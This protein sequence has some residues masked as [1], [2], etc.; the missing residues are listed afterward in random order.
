M[1]LVFTSCPQPQTHM[2]QKAKINYYPCHWMAS[3]T[4]SL[5]FNFLS[6]YFMQSFS[7]RSKSN[8]VHILKPEWLN[9]DTRFMFPRYGRSMTNISFSI[10]RNRMMELV[11]E[12]PR[13]T[14]FLRSKCHYDY[15]TLWY[16]YNSFQT[17]I[18]LCSSEMQRLWLPQQYTWNQN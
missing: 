8:N 18:K 2:E 14:H 6:H 9:F 7:F 10:N 17:K 12:N 16:I 13:Y 11:S 15:A 1:Y 4:L 3:S 5:T